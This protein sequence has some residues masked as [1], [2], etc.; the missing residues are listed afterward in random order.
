MEIKDILKENKAHA[1]NDRNI[2]NDI[3]SRAKQLCYEYNNLAPNQDERKREILNELFGDCSPLTF[4]EP[5][6]YCDYGFNIHTSGLTVINHNCVMLDTSPINIGSNVFIGPGV[7]LSC[8][9]HS[10]GPTQRRQGVATSGP[11][12][13]EDDVWIGANSTITANITIGKETIIGAGSV[14]TKDIPSGVVACGVP[15]KVIRKITKEDKE[16]ILAF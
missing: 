11:I 12:N 13:I 8:A 16:N 2:P 1:Y 3:K 10:K 9:G 15:C 4:I 6:F 14:V 5:N 7:V